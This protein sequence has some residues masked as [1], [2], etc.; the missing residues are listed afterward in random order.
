MKQVSQINSSFSAPKTITI[1]FQPVYIDGRAFSTI[2]SLM[3]SRSF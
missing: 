3:I 1:G 2:Y